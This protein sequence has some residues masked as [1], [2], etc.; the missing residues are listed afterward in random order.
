LPRKGRGKRKVQGHRGR[1][2]AG[3]GRRSVGLSTGG[4]EMSTGGAKIFA[5]EGK[6]KEEGSGKVLLIERDQG[7]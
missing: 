3:P 2:V 1:G 6:R 4:A 7:A 5:A